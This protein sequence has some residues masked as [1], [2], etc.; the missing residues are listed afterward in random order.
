MIKLMHKTRYD[1]SDGME[2]TERRLENDILEIERFRMTTR[3]FEILYSDI[4]KD[5]DKKVFE[6]TILFMSA[7]ASGCYIVRGFI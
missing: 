5:L 2:I 3:Q 7:S 1:Y 4:E 6:M